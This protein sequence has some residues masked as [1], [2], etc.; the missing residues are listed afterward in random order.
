M[1][2]GMHL[3]RA[4]P[5]LHNFSHAQAAMHICQQAE[6]DAVRQRPHPATSL[7]PESWLYLCIWRPVLLT[8]GRGPPTVVGAMVQV[9]SEQR[10][11]INSSG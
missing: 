9:E 4:A 1:R 8:V 3:H 5:G 10:T 7:A 2:T 11:A 6:M